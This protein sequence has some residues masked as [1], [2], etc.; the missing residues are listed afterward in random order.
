[1]S[2]KRSKFDE[3]FVRTENEATCKECDAK[4]IWT[5]TS[6]TNSASYHLSRYLPKLDEKKK[7][8]QLAKKKQLAKKNSLFLIPYSLFRVF[9]LFLIPYSLFR[10]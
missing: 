4:I 5:K 10:I 6:G 3:F 8:M 7:M 2:K 1:M 9:F